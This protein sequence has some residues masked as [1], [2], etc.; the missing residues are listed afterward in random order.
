MHR[1]DRLELLDTLAQLTREARLL[2]PEAPSVDRLARLRRMA[3][4]LRYMAEHLEMLGEAA[5]AVGTPDSRRR[6]HELI[7]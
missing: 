6:E 5:P 7:S 2:V 3:F 1:I 4:L